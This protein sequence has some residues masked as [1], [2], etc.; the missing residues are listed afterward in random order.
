M[1][2]TVRPRRRRQDPTVW[3]LYVVGL[4][5]AV[6]HFYQ[7][8]T[9]QLGADPVKTFEHLL[10]LWALR[11]LIL[12]LCVTPARDLFGWNQLR[13]RR[14]LGLLAFYYAL[15]HV[16]TYLV[17]DQALNFGAVIEDILRRPFITIGMGALLLLVPLALTSSDAAIRRLGSTWN[18]LHKLV[19]V[20]IAAGA[21]HYAMSVK[22]IVGEP[23]IYAGIVVALLAYR[24]V[25]KPLLRAR[26][27]RRE[28]GAAAL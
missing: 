23:L 11:F 26:R 27:R 28:A 17:L 7:G 20:A 9:G 21:L 13:Y 22:V 5:P 8:A 15:M 12:T 2:A 14:A 18:R 16:A 3:A 6:W 25:R 1:A 4:L 19:Y 24:A 10:G